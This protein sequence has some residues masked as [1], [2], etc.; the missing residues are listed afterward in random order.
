MREDEGSDRGQSPSEPFF[1]ATVR[2]VFA[3]V[4]RMN[5]DIPWYHSPEDGYRKRDER[6]IKLR[7]KSIAV[8]TVALFVLCLFCFSV[9]EEQQKATSIRSANG[10]F[11][12]GADKVLLDDVLIRA[13]TGLE[14]MDRGSYIVPAG[15]YSIVVTTDMEWYRLDQN[16]NLKIELPDGERCGA[17]DSCGLVYGWSDDDSTENKTL[18]VYNSELDQVT[19]QKGEVDYPFADFSHDPEGNT[20]Y[21]T[22]VTNPCSIYRADGSL[23]YTE[24]TTMHFR[25]QMPS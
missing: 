5:T 25:C 10:I 11:W 22:N 7:K 24:K 13:D 15:R 12:A 19:V 9:A 17:D 2:A 6:M 1:V 14:L 16:V 4:V 21:V 23:I 20:Y 18:C 3:D 8:L